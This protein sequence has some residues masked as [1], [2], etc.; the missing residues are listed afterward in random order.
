MTGRLSAS[1][2]ILVTAACAEG[3]NLGGGGEAGSTGVGNEGGGSSPSTSSMPSGPGS[4]STGCVDETCNGKDDNCDGTI[5]NPE[6][7]NG[8]ACETG[9]PGAC[10]SGT[11]LCQAGVL[12][13][14]PTVQP[15][16]QP[17]VCNAVDDDCNNEVDDLDANVACAAQN[18]DAENVESWSCLGECA[19]VACASATSD[20]NDTLSDG[21]ECVTDNAASQCDASAVVNVPLGGTVALSGV[22]E[23][24]GNSD[25]LTFEFQLSGVG[26][27]FHPRVELTNNAGGSYSMDVLVDC[28]GTA[29]GCSTSG[30]ANDGTGIAATV[31]EQNYA[32]YIPGAGCCSDA[33]PRQSVVRIRVNR[34]TPPACDAY[35]VTAT[36]Q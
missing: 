27:P 16:E 35:T 18:P 21:C 30:G 28:A 1:L 4:T 29:A 31:W 22:V 32:G 13:C 2:L 9:T 14:D 36:N 15:G 23:T 6:L 20:F 24:S 12:S 8:Q 19:I 5:D 17:E 3:G 25:W 33:T 34:T 10:G 7:L 26:Q 11:T